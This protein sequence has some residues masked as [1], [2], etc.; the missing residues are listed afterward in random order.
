MAGTSTVAAQERVSLSS[1]IDEAL[2]AHPTLVAADARRAA[3]T[4]RIAQER[5]LPDPMVS[6]G[7]ASV[8]LPL[9]GAG[10]RSEPLANLSVMVSQT[11]PYP[12]TRAL[13]ASAAMREAEAVAP[14]VD[15]ARLDIISRVKQLYYRLASVHATSDV[16][17][18]NVQLL[19]T[20]LQVSEGRYAVG[21]AAQQDV[22]KA[23]TELSIL[24]LQQRRL[25]QERLALDTELNTLRGRPPLAVVGRPDD[26]AFVPFEEQLEPMLA[27]ARTHAP[28]LQRDRLM[29]ASAETSIALARQASK[30]DITVSGGYAYS[31]A[32]PRMFEARVDVNVPFRKERRLAAVAE[33]SLRLQAAQA[34]L[35]SNERG[36]DAELQVEFRAAATASELARLYRDTVLP[37]ARL[38]LES[39]ISSY[40]SGAVDFLSVLTNFSSVLQYET[41]YVEELMNFH[42]A[43]S[44]VESMTGAPLVH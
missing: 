24:E 44:R 4:E 41:S 8:G 39:S 43:T 10:L 16:L 38:A 5:A 25:N 1:L 30:P 22:I 13:R 20:L 21:Q 14:L 9:P 23:Q 32:M 31:G 12:G 33:Q 18:R 36:L 34:D 3:A 19:D 11:F 2:T 7:Y 15:M 26:L 6:A 27:A 37:Q 28:M 17:A 40:E 35:A 29:I 42:V